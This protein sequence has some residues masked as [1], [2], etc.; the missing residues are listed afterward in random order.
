MKTLTMGFAWLSA[1]P[2]SSFPIDMVIEVFF[3]FG[4]L[5][6]SLTLLMFWT[7]RSQRLPRFRQVSVLHFKAL[8]FLQWQIL[9]AVEEAFELHQHSNEESTVWRSAIAQLS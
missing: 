1:V 3:F 7:H 4:L 8:F 9:L 5:I 6:L 2:P